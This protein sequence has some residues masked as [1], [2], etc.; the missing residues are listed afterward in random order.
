MQLI[1][2]KYLMKDEV[3][4][5]ESKTSILNS[6][7]MSLLDISWDSIGYIGFYAFGNYMPIHIPDIQKK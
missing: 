4:E 7:P 5:K 1:N 3:I 2:E 6:V